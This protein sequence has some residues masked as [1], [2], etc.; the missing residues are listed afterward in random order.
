[1]LTWL[2]EF[3]QTSS[4]CFPLI[5]DSSDVYCFSNKHTCIHTILCILNKPLL[6]FVSSLGYKVILMIIKLQRLCLENTHYN[7]Y[8]M[9]N[10]AYEIAN[11]TNKFC[12]LPL[13][14]YFSFHQ[15]YNTF[16]TGGSDGYVNIWDGQN[17]KR[18]C[19][20]HRYSSSISS[21]CFSHDGELV[22][23]LLCML[24]LQVIMHV[25]LCALI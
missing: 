18:L 21:L 24:F 2:A 8:E 4:Y 3:F 13:I 7:K 22:L 25:L 19:Q 5:T 23:C 16:A 20:F 14:C 12:L 11:E 6:K 9:V 15:G 17:K 10:F 1:M